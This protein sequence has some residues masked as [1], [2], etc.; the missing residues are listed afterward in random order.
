VEF[1][2]S[3]NKLQTSNPGRAKYNLRSWI[4]VNPNLAISKTPAL[5]PSSAY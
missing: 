3:T 5:L 1:E 4:A 2:P